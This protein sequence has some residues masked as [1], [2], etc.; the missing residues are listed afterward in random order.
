MTQ[1]LN[2]PQN[3]LNCAVPDSKGER[4]LCVQKSATILLM[5]IE[6]QFTNCVCGDNTAKVEVAA[7][8]GMLQFVP[9]TSAFAGPANRRSLQ[10]VTLIATD[11][12]P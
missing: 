2:S 7:L 5:S 8:D 6:S 9:A 1:Q 10:G 12:A 3:S 11:A 4:S